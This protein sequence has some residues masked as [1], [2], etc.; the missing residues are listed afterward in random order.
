MIYMHDGQ[1][2]FDPAHELLGLM[3][4]RRGDGRAEPGGL[5]A[6]VVGIP[7]MGHE[8]IA[9][10]SPFEQTEVGNAVEAYP[11]PRRARLRR[12]AV[13][14]RAAGPILAHAGGARPR[15][16]PH[17]AARDRE[18]APAPRHLPQH[19]R[20][21]AAMQPVLAAHGARRSVGRQR[22]HH[23]R[24]RH[25]QGARRAL[26]ARGV[27]ARAALVRRREHGRALRGRCSRASCSAT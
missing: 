27:A 11:A 21:V 4:R 7:N 15:A 6:I 1:N 19:D 18:P 25:R 17:A 20:R 5:D 22:A 8:R 9:E 10:Y 24:A 3:E 23:R 13:G 12:E 2:L 26:A 16:A 14:Q